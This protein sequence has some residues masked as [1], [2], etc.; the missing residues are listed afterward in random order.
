MREQN[1]ERNPRPDDTLQSLDYL[2]HPLDM[3]PDT[4][5]DRSDLSGQDPR[6]A[7]AELKSDMA[8]Y[9]LTGSSEDPRMYEL[10]ARPLAVQRFTLT[11]KVAFYLTNLRLF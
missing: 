3:V 1:P 6:D 11:Q 9:E 8:W 5:D 4:F 2:P 7:L 10:L